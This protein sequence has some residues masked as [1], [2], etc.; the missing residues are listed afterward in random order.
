MLVQFEGRSRES[1]A[2]FPNTV[3]CSRSLHYTACSLHH[4]VCLLRG[5]RFDELLQDCFVVLCLF[6]LICTFLPATASSEAPLCPMTDWVCQ[7]KPFWIPVEDSFKKAY[8]EEWVFICDAPCDAPSSADQGEVI[9]ETS[10]VSKLASL[11]PWEPA[12]HQDKACFWERIEAPLIP[13]RLR[14]KCDFNH[15]QQLSPFP[16]RLEL[17]FSSDAILSGCEDL[18]SSGS[19]HFTMWGKMSPH[20]ILAEHV[21]VIHK[22]VADFRDAFERNQS[23]YSQTRGVNNILFFSIT[24]AEEAQHL[25][26]EPWAPTWKRRRISE[27]NCGEVAYHYPAGSIWLCWSRYSS[28]TIS[29][30]PLCGLFNKDKFYPCISVKSIYLHDTRRGLQ[31]QVVEGEQGWVLQGVLSRASL[32]RAAVSGQKF[33][34]VLS[35]HISNIYAKKNG[36]AKKLILTIRAIMISQQIDLVAGDFNGTAWRC[37]SRD[38]LSTIDEAF[39]DCALPTPPGPTPLWRPGSIPNNWADVCRFLKPPGSQRFWKVSKHGAR[40]LFHWPWGKGTQ[41]NHQE[42]SQEIGNNSG[43]RYALQ[44]KQE[45]SAWGDPW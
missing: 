38:N 43:S 19:D 45:Q 29:R 41:R 39:A 30:D 31:D 25:Q 4:F 9:P 28:R 23:S 13:L 27:T 21:V 6:V 16:E 42:C 22:V 2:F 33:F 17:L 8:L 26:L 12:K 40:N 7:W 36:I 34:T 11:S 32:R 5:S 18:V 3:T 24:C 10:G 15:P 20:E 14:P 1:L 44:D 37:R 35:L